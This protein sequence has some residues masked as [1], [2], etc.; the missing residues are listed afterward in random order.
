V[1]G[2]DVKH[3]AITP[4][5]WSVGDPLAAASPSVSHI[6]ILSFGGAPATQREWQ[7]FGLSVES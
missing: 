4:R 7:V 6:G 5:W 1:T 2:T 3:G